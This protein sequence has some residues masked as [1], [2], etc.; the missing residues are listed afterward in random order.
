MSSVTVS[1]DPHVHSDESY[2]GHEPIELILEHAAE[3]GLDAVVITDHDV[4]G[5]SKRA[6]ELAPEYGLIGIPGVEVSTAHGHLLAVGVERMPPRRRPYDETIAWIHERGG[7]AIVPHPFQRSRHGVR[8]R[9]IPV[10]ETDDEGALVADGD[11]VDEVDAVEVFNAWL[12]T[13][14]RNRRARRFAATYDY[15]GVAASD[16]HHLEYVG[17]AFTEVRIEG[18]ESAADVTATDVLD[19]IRD[20]TTTV[21]GRRAP[22]RM[23]AKHYVGAAGRK[24]GYYARTGAVRSA[25]AARRGVAETLSTARVAAIQGTHRAARVLSWIT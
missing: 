10:P 22:I 3:I 23:A 17:R 20:G 14:Y 8:Q 4:I 24:S 19:A 12:F 11:P 13:G 16:A 25:T 15:P 21:D 7:V 5:E 2:D 9:N 1:I 6:A 18:R